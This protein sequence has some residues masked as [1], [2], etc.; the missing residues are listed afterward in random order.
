M[1]TTL[2]TYRLTQ[3]NFQLASIPCLYRPCRRYIPKASRTR[4][5]TTFLSLP[6]KHQVADRHV[7][8]DST[9]DHIDRVVQSPT[10][11]LLIPVPVIAIWCL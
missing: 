7:L 6:S 2:M 5:A 3:F 10:Q 4:I 1:P 9:V 8:G 11:Y